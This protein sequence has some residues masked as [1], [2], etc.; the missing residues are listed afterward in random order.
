MRGQF[1]NDYC[2]ARVRDLAR[3]KAS[4]MTICQTRLEIALVRPGV[5]GGTEKDA[6]VKLNEERLAHFK[7]ASLNK[8]K[9]NTTFR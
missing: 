5:V 6:S 4:K 2:T 8:A 1:Y 7:F 3:I 9:G